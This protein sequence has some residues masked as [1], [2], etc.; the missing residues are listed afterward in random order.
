MERASS[1][2]DLGGRLWGVAD[3]MVMMICNE[4]INRSM[5]VD[6]VVVC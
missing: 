5:K 2:V 1:A 4:L 6:V 3:M